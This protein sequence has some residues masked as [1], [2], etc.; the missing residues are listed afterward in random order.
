[1]GDSL[2]SPPKI[3]PMLLQW[4]PVWLRRC[5]DQL[6]AAKK[7]KEVFKYSLLLLPGNWSTKRQKSVCMDYAKPDREGRRCVYDKMQPWNTCAC[8]EGLLH[9]V[10][11]PCSS[12]AFSKTKKK[13]IFI[14]IAKKSEVC[15]REREKKKDWGLVL[16][17]ECKWFPK[18]VSTM[19]IAQRAGKSL[20]RLLQLF[21][22]P[23]KKKKNLL[24]WAQVAIFYKFFPIFRS[25]LGTVTPFPIVH[26]TYF[27]ICTSPFRSYQP[28]IM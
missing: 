7:K 25:D 19:Q 28:T 14:L 5:R 20:R 15:S 1:M 23:Q 13:L 16:H 2:P 10:Y 27:H 24:Q 26:P 17:I 12:Y 3:T 22:L 8:N 18:G 9:G 4:D 11:M 6:L 21:I